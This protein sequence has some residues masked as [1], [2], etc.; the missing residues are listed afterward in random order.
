MLF[1]NLIPLNII[2]QTLYLSPTNLYPI[3]FQ[4]FISTF[5]SSA[6]LISVGCKLFGSYYRKYWS[7]SASALPTLWRPGYDRKKIICVP[8]LT[9]L[10]R[11]LIGS[12]LEEG[13]KF[14]KFG[15][16]MGGWHLGVLPANNGNNTHLLHW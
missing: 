11:C 10:Y 15:L 4:Q 8:I 6:D 7:N 12:V 9:G 14:A 13:P 1:V 2:Q 16:A 5:L 3:R